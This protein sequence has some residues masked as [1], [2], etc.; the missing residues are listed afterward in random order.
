MEY[1]QIDNPDALLFSSDTKKI[2]KIP[3]Q[4]NPITIDSLLRFNV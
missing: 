2:A 4:Y 3:N 1:Y